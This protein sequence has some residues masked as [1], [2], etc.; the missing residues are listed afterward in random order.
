LIRQEKAPDDAGAFQMSD[1]GLMPT[2]DQNLAT[3]GPPTIGITGHETTDHRT[4]GPAG[5]HRYH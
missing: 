4:P 3:T 2:L 5:H 1:D